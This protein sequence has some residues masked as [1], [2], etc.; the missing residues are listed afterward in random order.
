MKTINKPVTKECD[1][2]IGNYRHAGCASQLKEGYCKSRLPEIGDK[3]IRMRRDH[4]YIHV[5]IYLP[6]DLYVN[7]DD[8]LHNHF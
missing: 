4:P 5:Y 6:P 3:V 8:S 1:V 2:E 7:T